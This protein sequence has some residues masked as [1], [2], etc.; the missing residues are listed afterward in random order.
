MMTTAPTTVPLTI[1]NSTGQD[2]SEIYLVIIGLDAN[3]CWAYVNADGSTTEFSATGPNNYLL[4][5][6]SLT[7]NT[8]N[9]PWLVSGQVYFSVGSPLT[10]GATSDAKQPCGIGVQVPAGWTTSDPNYDVMYD[11]VEFTFDAGGINCDLTQ[12]DAFGLPITLQIVGQNGTQ[13]TGAW[14]KTRSEM[15]A[16]FTSDATLGKLVITSGTP[17]DQIDLRIL[18]PSHAIALGLFPSDFFDDAIA[19]YWNTYQNNTLTITLVGGSFPGT[20][21]ATTGGKGA[22]MTITLGGTQVGQI[23]YPTTSEVFACNGT[24]DQG[25]TAMGAV[26][27][28]VVTAINRG[29]LG[30][31]SQPDC[32]VSDF[33]PAKGTWNGYAQ[34]LHSLSAD[35]LCYAFA[36]DDQCA[37]SSDLADPA[38][39][40]WNITLESVS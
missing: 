33:Y 1:T 19:D 18:N 11:V 32:N 25:N 38:P 36:Y 2:D 23:T 8:V 27:N 13:T 16:E 21:Q 29:I 31:S 30:I 28:V 7:N 10:F 34:L 15:F 5:L 22:P 40:S 24:F 17:P 12:V 6:S 9:V 20:Y 39:T 35:G 37:Q 26:A 14:N 3:G 4:Q